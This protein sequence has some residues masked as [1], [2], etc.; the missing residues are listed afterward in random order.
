MCSISV[1]SQFFFLAKSKVPARL[2]A[3]SS[4]PS[5]TRTISAT[6]STVSSPPSSVSS[7]SASV[8]SAATKLVQ[9]TDIANDNSSG[10]SSGSS[11]SSGSGGAKRF[12][13]ELQQ[14]PQPKS[15]VICEEL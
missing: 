7:S 8:S 2:T 4:A 1:Y 11:G 10:S 5:H 15:D 3:T 6:S 9:M 14:P 13:I 12:P